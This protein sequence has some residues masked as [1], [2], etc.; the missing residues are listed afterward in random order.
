[1]KEKIKKAVEMGIPISIKTY[2]LPQ[3]ITEYITSVACTFL[4]LIH[5]KAIQD[6]IVY[7]LHELITN[8]KK[9]NTK[10]VY[11]KIKG[12]D[13]NDE[14]SYTEGMK[15]FKEESLNNLDYY[16]QQ[17]KK[18]G[19]YIKV[20]MQ[21][22]QD[23]IIIEVLNNVALVAFERHRIFERIRIAHAYESVNEALLNRV[24]TTE[25]AG[26]GFIIMLLMLKKIGLQRDALK[27]I[28][29]K[30][31]TLVRITIPGQFEVD[32][33]LVELTHAVV[34]YIENLPQFP[35]KI[36]QIQ[37]LINDPNA[38]MADIASLINNDIALTADLLK[39]VN[40][41]AF[42]LAKKCMNISEAV[43]LA[44][45][46][47]IQNLLYS[48]GTLQILGNDE[49]GQKD[50][51]KQ[52]YKSAFFAYYLAKNYRKNSILDDIYVCALLHKLGKF[53]LN[54]MYPHLLSR[55]TEIQR[56]K[57]IAP[58]I[59]NKVL[60]GMEHHYIGTLLAEKWNL[61]A[62]IVASIKY[63]Y[64]PE[65]APKEWYELIATISF[66]DALIHYYAGIITYRQIPI[67]L[68]Q[69]YRIADEQQLYTI[70]E[71]LNT[72]FEQ[73]QY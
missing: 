47:A 50:L 46:R 42:G 56:E 68:L 66:A 22:K 69:L 38:R 39:L 8:A 6:Y 61:P 44:G 30:D 7:C 31:L 34:D 51:W 73:K 41:A 16:L 63:Q 11:F 43:K 24:D 64:E 52:A 4:E 18:E 40:S 59:V 25:G 13:I 14:N 26:L 48:I 72:A 17:Q 12:L 55:I 19:L 23:A 2:T 49:Q 33:Q 27:I 3:E 67:A 37:R 65:K 57:H 29:A 58:E 15:T 32:H 45:L 28:T 60:S 62:I 21:T 10:R 54:L 35:E 70:A 1:M 71:K 53:V 36:M 20:R 5:Q 9:A